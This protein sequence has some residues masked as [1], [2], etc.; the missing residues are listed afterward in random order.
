LSP[1]IGFGQVQFAPI[2]HPK[3]KSGKEF[4]SVFAALG[5]DKSAFIRFHVITARQV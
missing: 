1:E 5:R 2:V 3:M 4:P